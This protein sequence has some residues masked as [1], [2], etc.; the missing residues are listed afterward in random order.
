MDRVP[1]ST[2][3]VSSSSAAVITMPLMTSSRSGSTVLVDA[4]LLACLSR[5]NTSINC[6]ACYDA[7]G[8]GGELPQ[9]KNTALSSVETRAIS[10]RIALREGCALTLYLYLLTE[11][12]LKMTR[13]EFL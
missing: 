2:G 4:P 10:L 6:A 12:R 5:D 13:K 1:V 8:V 9:L 7:G 3:C 11:A